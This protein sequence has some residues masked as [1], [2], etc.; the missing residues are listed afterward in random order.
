MKTQREHELEQE[1]YKL[2]L[3]LVEI[4]ELTNNVSYDEDDALTDRGPSTAI[5]RVR[6]AAFIAKATCSLRKPVNV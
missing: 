5:G 6:A 1:V 4:E 3:A 2:L